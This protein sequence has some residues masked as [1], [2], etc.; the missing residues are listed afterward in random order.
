MIKIPCPGCKIIQDT[1]MS[2]S[3]KILL[4]AGVIYLFVAVTGYRYGIDLFKDRKVYEVLA[5]LVLFQVIVYLILC[6]PLSK[7]PLRIKSI[8]LVIVGLVLLGQLLNNSRKFYPFSSWRMYSTAVPDGSVILLEST[9]SDG[10]SIELNTSMFSP[11]RSSRP[12]EQLMARIVNNRTREHERYQLLM[13][14][15]CE[16][17]QNRGWDA[18]SIQVMLVRYGPGGPTD[19]PGLIDEYQCPEL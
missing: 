10:N 11:A 9:N 14:Y 18:E 12:H 2:E 15:Y 5:Y 16:T 8:M 19:S 17:L 4:I 3:S 7:L 1:I 6:E 13:D